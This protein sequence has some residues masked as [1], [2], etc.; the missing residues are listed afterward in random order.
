[1]VFCCLF[2]WDLGFFLQVVTSVDYFIKIGVCHFGS[3]FFYLF[4][5]VYSLVFS[6]CEGLLDLSVSVSISHSDAN[7]YFQYCS[8]LPQRF[9]FCFL[10]LYVIFLVF[11]G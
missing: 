9:C 2:L 1:V 3:L 11:C 6:V 4:F 10:S 8:V 7:D 5:V